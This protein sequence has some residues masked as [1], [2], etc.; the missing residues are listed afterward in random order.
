VTTHEPASSPLARAAHAVPPSGARALSVGGRLVG[1]LFALYVAMD[2][3]YD[4]TQVV[5]FVV[6]AATV[7]SIV[8][9]SGNSGAIAAAC[10]AGL[11]FFAGAALAAEAPLAGA[12][13]L[14]SGAAAVCGTLVASFRDGR[15]V[16][17]ALAGFFAAMPLLVGGVALIALVVEG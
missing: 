10:G 8:P 17:W 11:L 6:A 13:M 12:A 3:S 4:R 7:L 15:H 9:L 1:A 14:A 2:Q 5:C 16:F